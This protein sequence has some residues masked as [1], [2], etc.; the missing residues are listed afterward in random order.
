MNGVNTK[1]THRMSA[2]GQKQTLALQ[3]VMSALPPKAD[4][5][6]PAALCGGDFKCSESESECRKQRQ[7][8]LRVFISYSRDDLKLADQ[9]DAVLTLFGFDCLIDRHGISGGEDWKRKDSGIGEA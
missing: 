1:S 4:K 9:L 6:G 2:L 3:K 8:K 5:L 7:D